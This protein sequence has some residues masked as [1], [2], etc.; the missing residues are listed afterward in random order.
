MLVEYV[1]VLVLVSLPCALAVRALG[2]PLVRL[3][4]VEKAVLLLPLSF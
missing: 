1:M 2:P 3:F 4:L